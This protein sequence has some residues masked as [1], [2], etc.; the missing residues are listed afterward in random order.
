MPF[1][2]LCGAFVVIAVNAQASARKE[3]PDSVGQW[4]QQRGM[5]VATQGG[6][7]PAG[8]FRV[9]RLADLDAPDEVKQQLRADIERSKGVVQVAEGSIPTQD[10]MLA[11][12]PRR[13]RSAPELRQRLP[14]PPSRLEGSL[15][16]P[17]Q[18]I[19]MEP[20]GALDGGKSSGLS[21]YYRL[22][23]VGTVEFSE[24]NF[25]AAGTQIEVIAEAQNTLVN[26]KPAHLGRA[27]DSAGRT[28]VELA[29]TGVSK[30]YSLIATGEPGSDVE[31]NAR[32]LHDIAAAIKD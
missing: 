31:R 9:V 8:S 27:V 12:L 1:L 10:E 25:V 4:L 2:L 28:R 16:G 11:A 26:G 30:T 32:T 6:R 19:G 23:G 3:D 24:N 15:L 20:S 29:W 5:Q 22:Q 17:A 21:R 7:P 13:H 14:Q 18:L